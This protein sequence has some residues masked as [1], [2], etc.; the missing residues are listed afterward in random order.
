MTTTDHEQ[1]ADL[2]RHDCDR[3]GD[4]DQLPPTEEQL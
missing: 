1:H 2:E 4:D 3:Y